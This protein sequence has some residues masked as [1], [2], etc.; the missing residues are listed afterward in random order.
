MLEKKIL[1]VSTQL[2]Y[3]PQSGGTV[4][5]WNFVKHLAK[6]NSL[7][8]A[9][10]LKEDDYKHEKEFLEKIQLSNYKS[11]PLLI[12]RTAINLIKSYFL[13]PCLNLFRN[14]SEEMKKA[15]EELS[16]GQDIII[17]DHYEVFQYVPKDF[18]GKVV[19]HTHN[20][21]F[22]LWKRMSELS[23]NW[24]KKMILSFEAFR[25]K[26]YEKKIF[27]K[28]DLVF[29]TPS[30]IELYSKEAFPKENLRVTFHLGND[31]LLDLPDIKFSETNKSLC[32]MGTLSWEPNIDGL[33]W[34]IEM[35][36]PK[37]LKAIPDC[38]LEVLG[39]NPDK[40]LLDAAKNSRNI[41]FCGFV[42]DLNSKLKTTRVFIAPLRF[43]SGMKVKVLDGL[44]RGVP[45]VLTTVAAEGIT[46]KDGEHALVSDDPKIFASHCVRLLEDRLLWEKIQSNSRVLARSNYL[47]E[48][49]FV[50]MDW[51][52]NKILS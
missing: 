27:A 42:K 49:L 16:P 31:H 9:C 38:Q 29:A 33:A 11:V 18:K 2:P 24:I 12:P 13:A 36:W 5:S 28:A 48:D 22:M 21:E 26:V 51:E 32:F 17:I 43:G 4:K 10:L 52:M 25:V 41:N 30:D 40:R 34:F 7:S 47:W 37:I 8:I 45:S 50:K 39:S 46:I 44:Y 20:A 35:A 15:V 19:L 23:S 6:N 1:F 3:P 14:R